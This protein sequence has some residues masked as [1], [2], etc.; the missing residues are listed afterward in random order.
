VAEDPAARLSPDEVHRGVRAGILVEET[1]SA[2]RLRNRLY[3]LAAA[4]P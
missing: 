1:P 4:R 2:R 3:A